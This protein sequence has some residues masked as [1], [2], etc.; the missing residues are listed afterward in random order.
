MIIYLLLALVADTNFI[1]TESTL[2]TPT[3]TL[4]VLESDFYGSYAM[5]FTS[6]CKLWDQGSSIL[7]L[8][9]HGGLFSIG[10]QLGELPNLIRY[11]RKLTDGCTKMSLLCTSQNLDFH[12]RIGYIP[13]P[14]PVIRR[15]QRHQSHI[16]FVEGSWVSILL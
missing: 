7:K 16:C 8:R 3:D 12:D 1:W 4:Y 13:K 14:S 6:E 10:S 11:G 2:D 15:I 5:T 9:L